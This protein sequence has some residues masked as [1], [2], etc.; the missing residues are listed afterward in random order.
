MRWRTIDEVKTGKGDKICANVACEQTVDLEPM[1]VVFGYVEDGKSK[2]VLVKCVVCAPCRRK[3]KRVQGN[4]K[5]RRSSR[6]RDGDEKDEGKKRR[7]HHRRHGKT[8]DKSES[9]HGSSIED[10][11]T[12]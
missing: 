6:R 1:E 7:Q 4:D 2:N 5:E 8:S 12:S 11:K 10:K 3:M 9:R